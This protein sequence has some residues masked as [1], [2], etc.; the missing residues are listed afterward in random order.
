VSVNSPELSTIVGEMTRKTSL[1]SGR[2]RLRVIDGLSSESFSSTLLFKPVAAR[3]PGAK[4]ATVTCRFCV[5]Y[6]RKNI[7]QTLMQTMSKAAMNIATYLEKKVRMP[8]DGT[9]PS[10]SCGLSPPTRCDDQGGNFEPIHAKS[11][12]ESHAVRFEF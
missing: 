3:C 8:V 5:N 7:N 2:M 10:H 9:E 11:R 12:H 4:V 1:E 6:K